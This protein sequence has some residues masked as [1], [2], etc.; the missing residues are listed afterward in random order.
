[1]PA[2]QT[3]S[4]FH[5]LVCP[6]SAFHNQIFRDEKEYAILKDIRAASVDLDS[7]FLVEQ[8]TILG[9]SIRCNKSSCATIAVWCSKSMRASVGNEK[10][11]HLL[12]FNGAC[13]HFAE[14]D[15]WQSHNR[16]PKQ[17]DTSRNVGRCQASSL[18]LNRSLQEIDVQ[19]YQA[20]VS[21]SFR[22]LHCSY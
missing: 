8:I 11:V 9:V 16:L 14:S 1:M 6:E 19:F 17:S 10:T 2:L 18:L 15:V 12:H 4:I 7:V 20:V 3:D 5:L 22:C 13:S 21:S